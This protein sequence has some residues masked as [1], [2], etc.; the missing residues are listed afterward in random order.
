MCGATWYL[1]LA[2]VF[3]KYVDFVKECILLEHFFRLVGNTLHTC[4][5][6]EP[7]SPP[8]VPGLNHAHLYLAQVF[9]KYGQ[10][11]RT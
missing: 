1:Y 6:K 3:E 8:L 7:S 9:E 2:H 10:E 4:S 11:G 5:R